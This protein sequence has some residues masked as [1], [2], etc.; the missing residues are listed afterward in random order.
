[1]KLI[2]PCPNCKIDLRFPIDFGTVKITCPNCKNSF[3]ANPDNPEL[4]K[5]SKFDLKKDKKSLPSLN[6]LSFLFYFILF[7]G[8]LF[9]L[10]DFKKI[11]SELNADEKIIEEPNDEKNEI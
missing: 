4:Y 1:M 3:L 9:L 5:E 8:V 10:F 11:I 2:R 7:L 6:I